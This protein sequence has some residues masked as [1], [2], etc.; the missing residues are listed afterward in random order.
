LYYCLQCESKFKSYN[1][2]PKYCSKKCKDESSKGEIDIAKMIV[3]YEKGH[4]QAEIASLLSTTQKV[5]HSR[6]K[7]IGYKARIARKRNQY[8]EN[9]SHWKDGVV[10][11]KGYIL[12]R[13]IG[14]PRASNNG[15]YVYQHV[16]VM[17]KQIG[18][19]L[20][21]NGPNDPNS[22]IVH[23]KNEIKDDNKI[24]N[25]ELMTVSEHV[26]LHN[27]LRSEREWSLCQ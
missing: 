5:I 1:K 17:E 22:E 15:N 12:E 20:K 4:T 26:R 21:W 25:L 27:K 23:H 3:L 8:A 13:C 16:L 6:M 9:N 11:D 10:R 14:H 19:Y 2:K 24:D 7:E 18:R